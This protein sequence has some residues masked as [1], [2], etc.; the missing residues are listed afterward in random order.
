MLFWL[1]ETGKI[2][3]FQAFWSCSVDF[4]H[5]CDPLA[6]IGHMWGFWRTCGSKCRGEGGGIFPTLCVEC[7]LV[8]I[9]TGPRWLWTG[10]PLLQ[11]IACGLF[12][13]AKQPLEPIRR[14]PIRPRGKKL[15][16]EFSQD[17]RVF[18]A[19]MNLKILSA[20]CQLFVGLNV[21]H[22]ARIFLTV[23]VPWPADQRVLPTMEDWLETISTRGQLTHWGWDKMAD[24]FQTTY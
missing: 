17:T 16:H 2:W 12:N 11:G 21:P 4:P 14:L 7:C 9:E 10:S 23:T 18:I 6:D 5:Y 13:A 3:G 1:S 8:Y 22:L 20:K 24:S 15:Q 19:A